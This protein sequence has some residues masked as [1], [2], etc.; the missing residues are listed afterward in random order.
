MLHPRETVTDHTKG[1]TTG[2]SVVYNIDARGAEAGVEQKILQALQAYDR[3]LPS[4]VRQIN[5]DP[6]KR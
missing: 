2:G 5:A 3:Q 1:Q 4:R 6:R